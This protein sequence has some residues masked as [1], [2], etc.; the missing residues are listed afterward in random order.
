M[1]GWPDRLPGVPEMWWRRGHLVLYSVAVWGD[2]TILAESTGLSGGGPGVG[3]SQHTKT[4]ITTCYG[5]NRG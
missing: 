1:A 2:C 5:G 3:D 4:D